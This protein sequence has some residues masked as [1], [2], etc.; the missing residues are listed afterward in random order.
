VTKQWVRE[1]VPPRIVN[2]AAYQIQRYRPRIEGLFA[3]VERWTNRADPKD[4]FWRSISR[5]NITTWYGRTEE[6]R[7]AATHVGRQDVIVPQVV[8]DSPG[9]FTRLH[10]SLQL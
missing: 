1:V 7:F 8:C 10:P 3:R 9:M 6:S 2:G 4:S 5:D